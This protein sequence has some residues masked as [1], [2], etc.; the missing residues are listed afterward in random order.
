MRGLRV[1][2]HRPDVREPLPEKAAQPQVHAQPQVPH[3]WS[4]GGTA[5][6]S[7]A[8]AGK[9]HPMGD[10][11]GGVN[12]APATSS[13]GQ[14]SAGLRGRGDRCRSH[15]GRSRVELA[16]RVLLPPHA[17]AAAT[18]VT[19]AASAAAAAAAATAKDAL[20]RGAGADGAALLK[21]DTTL[22][23]SGM[24]AAPPHTT[25]SKWRLWA[26][27]PLARLRIDE[28]ELRDLMHALY[29]PTPSSKGANRAFGGTGGGG[30][31]R[32]RFDKRIW[33]AD[34][35]AGWWSCSMR[36][37]AKMPGA[38]HAGGAPVRP[39]KAKHATRDDASRSGGAA[40]SDG[41]TPGKPSGGGHATS[42][43]GALA[44]DGGASPSTPTP[45]ESTA[46]MPASGPALAGEAASHAPAGVPGSPVP[47]ADVESPA[48]RELRE[49]FAEWCKDVEAPACAS[50]KGTMQASA[51]DGIAAGA[52][53]EDA[54]DALIGPE[55]IC[56]QGG[57]ICVQMTLELK[58]DPGE[59]PATLTAQV[60]RLC[61]LTA[62]L[63]EAPDDASHYYARACALLTNKM[64]AEAA[65]DA[66]ACLRLQPK[67]AKARFAKGRALYFLGEYESAFAQYDAGLRLEKNAKIEA[68]LAA[69][70]RKPEYKVSPGP[71][72]LLEKLRE[73]IRDGDIKRLAVV[74]CRCPAD[75]LEGG[76]VDRRGVMTPPLHL[77]A[78]VGQ[79]D[80]CV[81]LLQRSAS[82]DSRDAAGR[83]PLMLALDAG[84][85]ECACALLPHGQSSDAACQHGRTALHRAAAAGLSAP[86]ALL[87]ARGA[88]AGATDARGRNVLH[89]ACMAG[90]P[91]ILMQVANA[92]AAAATDTPAQSTAA[93][94]ASDHDGCTPMALAA[95]AAYQGTHR[96]AAQ[97][98]C[99]QMCLLLGARCDL[100][101]SPPPP[102]IT[103][104]ANAAA[105]AAVEALPTAAPLHHYLA[106]VG[107][108]DTLLQVIERLMQCARSDAAAP[109]PPAIDAPCASTGL[110]VLHVAAAH[111]QVECAPAPR[112]GVLRARPRRRGRPV[113]VGSRA[114]RRPG[115]L[116]PRRGPRRVPPASHAPPGAMSS[117]QLGERERE[118]PQRR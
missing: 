115:A 103:P 4:R 94:D 35:D 48:Q 29:G 17:S 101:P 80:C 12:P 42:T 20:R 30:G 92:A 62:A 109:P 46:Q 40:A 66:D 63:R 77:A 74:L 41:A 23:V 102:P 31:G 8:A 99:V 64:Y 1:S 37:L 58:R 104:M 27:L 47:S 98:H 110:G 54:A 51:S 111:G 69:E 44:A 83:T 60:A 28:S 3:R 33:A 34:D 71:V 106:A 18:T 5:E 89:E 70:R 25:R 45:P 84:H 22:L 61:Q 11:P 81:L 79:V 39:P 36:V 65:H 90:E 91:A 49:E 86:V 97:L 14:S 116:P 10:A 19:E 24:M 26:W 117:A 68:W 95:R 112:V 21:C 75:A 93:L 108:A 85:T 96:R 72:A 52:A 82:L 57:G 32:P 105:A 6:A 113:A 7:N 43:T 73:A 114:A 76:S 59:L 2:F 107:A 87:I 13:E 50:A 38:A 15:G 67:Y 100:P 56:Y 118:R 78:S 9:P 55:A 88:N 53:M 16:A